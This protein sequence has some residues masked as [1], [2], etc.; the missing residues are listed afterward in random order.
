[1]VI[2]LG[3]IMDFLE[4]SHGENLHLRN[5]PQ[6]P[7]MGFSANLWK[8]GGSVKLIFREDMN[9]FFSEI[10]KFSAISPNSHKWRMDIKMFIQM[11]TCF[12]S[13]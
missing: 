13:T 10:N 4:S 7:K 5:F 1:M 8:S 3:G 11:E 2:R 6:R 9:G 12:Y